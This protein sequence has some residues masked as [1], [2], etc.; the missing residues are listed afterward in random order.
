LTPPV[1]FAIV[2]AGECKM[3]SRRDFIKLLGLTG[4]IVLAPLRFLGQWS[5]R[6][7]SQERGLTGE[8]YNGFL[9]LEEG[10]QIPEFVQYPTIPMPIG[11]G[12]GAEEKSVNLSAICRIFETPEDLANEMAF[13]V[14][15]LRE[16]PNGIRCGKA[17]TLSNSNGSLYEASLAYESYNSKTQ[18][19]ETTISF[20]IQL[21][22]PKPLPLWS[23]K[24]VENDVPGII[25]DKVNFLPNPGLRMATQRG[26][27]YY[28]IEN[29]I[30]YTLGLEPTI[31]ETITA[32][33]INRLD[34]SR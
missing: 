26:L 27:V 9:L 20:L 7:F 24:S 4:G 8:L 25:Y 31:N 18:L 1:A 17:Y 10:T 29:D 16:L 21:H 32:D 11:C 14:Y 22:Y 15:L 19:W 12:V 33:I 30:F 34:P 6:D 28:W 23:M 13:R 3:I 5:K 2:D